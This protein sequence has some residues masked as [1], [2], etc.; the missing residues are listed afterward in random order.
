GFH[1]DTVGGH[2]TWTA[3]IAAGSISA[4]GA[5]TEAAC[6]DDELFG[7]AGGCITPSDVDSMLGNGFFDLDLFCPTYDCDGNTALSY[8]L[9][10]EPVQTLHQNGGVAP[11]AKVS[12]FDNSYTDDDVYGYLAGNLVWDSAKETGAKIHS[13]SWEA[14]TFCQITELELMYDTYMYEVR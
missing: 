7:C 5:N 12:V 14:I 8:C 13:N 11:G 2:G 6:Y 9:S 1:K 4:S 10:D 3:G